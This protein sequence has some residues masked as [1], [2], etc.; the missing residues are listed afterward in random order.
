[1]ETSGIIVEKFIKFLTNADLM[2]D[3]LVSYPYSVVVNIIWSFTHFWFF[4]S[5]CRKK[6]LA[7]MVISCRNICCWN[8]EMVMKSLFLISKREAWFMASLA[9]MRILKW[10]RANFLFLNMMGNLV[11]MF[12]LLGITLLR[13][14]TP[15]WFMK[16]KRLVLEM[17][18]LL[19]LSQT[20][21]PF[22]CLG[23]SH[24]T[25]FL[26]FICF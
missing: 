16:H 14:T 12:M 2:S 13:L 7:N 1:M 9:C 21:F 22:C 11:L 18:C 23:P 3:E 19:L 4:F 26:K 10:N 8:F 15:F 17:V 20:L 6:F 25:D 5:C 24:C